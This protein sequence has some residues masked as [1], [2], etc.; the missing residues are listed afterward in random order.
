MLKQLFNDVI[1]IPLTK[2]YHWL[3]GSK[4]AIASPPKETPKRIEIENVWPRPDKFTALMLAH[5]ALAC[6]PGDVRMLQF[7]ELLFN[8]AK[9][10]KSEEKP[11]QLLQDR[12]ALLLGDRYLHQEHHIGK[13]VFYYQRVSAESHRYYSTANFQ[14]A[15][16][17]LESDPSKALRHCEAA[18]AATNDADAKRLAVDLRSRQLSYLDLANDPH[19][20]VSGGIT[21]K[22][23][24]LFAR[25][26]STP[27]ARLYDATIKEATLEWEDGMEAVYKRTFEEGNDNKDLKRSLKNMSTAPREVIQLAAGESQQKLLKIQH[28]HLKPSTFAQEVNKLINNYKETY[29]SGIGNIVSTADQGR[30]PTICAVIRRKMSQLQAALNQAYQSFNDKLL[31]EACTNLIDDSFVGTVFPYGWFGDRFGFRSF[32][33]E[34]SSI[35]YKVKTKTLT[36][37]DDGKVES[38]NFLCRQSIILTNTNNSLNQRI[39]N[40]ESG[41]EVSDLK[42]YIKKQD[43]TIEKHEKTI[44]K[45][46]TIVRDLTEELRVT[47]EELR[48]T[49][50]ELR[51]TKEE[52]RTTKEELRVMKATNESLQENFN[53]MLLRMDEL[54][55]NFC[56]TKQDIRQSIELNSGD[57]KQ[58]FEKTVNSAEQSKKAV[59][60]TLKIHEEKKMLQGKESAMKENYEREKL[61]WIC[62]LSKGNRKKI[63]TFPVFYIADEKL[64]SGVLCDKK[65]AEKAC[66]KNKKSK[67]KEVDKTQHESCQRFR[68]HYAELIEHDE[69][70]CISKEVEVID[71]ENKEKAPNTNLFAMK[72]VGSKQEDETKRNSLTE[73]FTKLFK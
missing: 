7:A 16:L 39:I 54:E 29:M 15:T 44:E 23:T 21:P 56:N 2:A 53:K 55:R 49:K 57:L 28:E 34:I 46:N 51:V 67:I 59:I 36:A 61:G 70:V 37:Y 24:D 62:P 31:L 43:E 63:I 14:L 1:A 27:K 5:N 48:V 10:V 18:I 26:K 72:G 47:K 35:M 58:S 6:F 50:E 9:R 71:S 13:A 40:L 68:K 30:H 38:I 4:L 52:L 22:M 64:G 60:Q 69:D 73:K 45:Q 65:S 17:F 19:T 3:T 25:R 32:K 66:L 8:K 20:L 12:L 42:E 11:V 41:Q 33:N